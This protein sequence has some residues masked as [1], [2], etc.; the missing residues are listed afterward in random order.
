VDLGS[1]VAS[2]LL[3]PALP[4]SLARY[5]EIR[6]DLGVSDRDID[7]I[8]DNVDCVIRGGALAD[9]GRGERSAS[10]EGVR[11]RPGAHGGDQRP[12]G[13]VSPSEGASL[14]AHKAL[15]RGYKAS[16]RAD[17]TPC[18]SH[19][20][21]LMGGECEFVSVQHQGTPSGLRFSA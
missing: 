4:D 9:T 7:L 5:P 6:M 18:R 1:S 21:S 13:S 10:F 20:A 2:R 12:R 14:R 8:G 17:K 19:K 15:L 11:D 16:P 3:V